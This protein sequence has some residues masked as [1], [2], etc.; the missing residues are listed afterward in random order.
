MEAN[1]SSL[2][3]RIPDFIRYV[4]WLE[5][6]L[7]RFLNLYG[8]FCTFLN[9]GDDTLIFGTGYANF[10]FATA[11]AYACFQLVCVVARRKPIRVAY[12]CVLKVNQNIKVRPGI[13]VKDESGTSNIK[14]T[15]IYSR[16]VSLYEEKNEL[17]Y[18]VPGGLIG[19]GTTMDPML[20]RVD[21]LVCQVLGE[22]VFYSC[23]CG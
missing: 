19:V 17:Q 9:P 15:L 5:E 16:I 11:M 21:P 6:N 12:L 22:V 20:T 4:W 8:R 13:V 7:I 1:G 10:Y 18:V 2:S 3:K 23:F 14:W